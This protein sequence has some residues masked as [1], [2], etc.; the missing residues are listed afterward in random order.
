VKRG[1]EVLICDR[2]RAVTHPGQPPRGRDLEERPRG[3]CP[4][5]GA[6]VEP[7][8]SYCPQCGTRL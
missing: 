3:S 4:G 2:C 5:C 7:A 8:F 6:A 1:E